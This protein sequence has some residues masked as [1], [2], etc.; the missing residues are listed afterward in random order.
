MSVVLSAMATAAVEPRSPIRFVG[1]QLTSPTAGS[2]STGDIVHVDNLVGG[3]AKTPK[4]GDLIIVSFGVGYGTDTTLSI[5]GGT[6]ATTINDSFSNDTY[7]LQWFTGY[8]FYDGS[9]IVANHGISSYRMAIGVMVF[10]YVD[11]VTPMDVTPNTSTIINSASV[12]PTQIYPVTNGAVGVYATLNATNIADGR[13][14]APTSGTLP[15]FYNSIGSTNGIGWSVTLGMGIQ[16]TVNGM[17]DPGNHT[18]SGSVTASYCAGG[19]ATLA[20]RPKYPS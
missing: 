3:I 6:N 9:T 8:T 12:D 2:T 14:I 11:D 19:R 13:F 7:D 10:R 15:T 20:L 5:T 16:P 18:F 4:Y 17:I 1:Q